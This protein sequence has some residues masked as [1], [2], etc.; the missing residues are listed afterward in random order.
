MRA[1]RF[2]RVFWV[3]LDGMG[4]AHARLVSDRFPSL[5]RIESEG[6]LGPSRPSSPVCQTPPALLALF[7]GAQ[8]AESGVWGYRMPDP[9]R[10]ERSVSGFHAP[11]GACRTIWAD[12]EE[13]GVGCSLMNVAFRSDPVWSAGEA[14]LD[15]ACDAYRLWTRPVSLRLQGRR[16]EHAFHGIAF[17]T[18]PRGRGIAITRGSALCG[19]LE[20]GEAAMVT[21]T[22]GC[23]AFAQLL[24]PALLV[25]CPLI[26]AMLRGAR[27]PSRMEAR[28]GPTALMQMR[29]GPAAA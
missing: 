21:L 26:P 18:V 6:F 22:R 9:A 2:E 15:F 12:L 10:I 13:T 11:V 19:L 24:D 7:A 29:F 23:R 5:S 16:Q 1:G 8:P 25:F 17:H 27:L 3:V 4:H 20:P 28:A 14:R